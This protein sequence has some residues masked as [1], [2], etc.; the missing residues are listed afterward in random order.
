MAAVALVAICMG[1]FVMDAAVL[2]CALIAM[3]EFF[4]AF[5]QKGN[6]PVF[7]AGIVFWLMLAV[8]P[9]ASERGPGLIRFSKLGSINLFGVFLLASLIWIFAA[10][11]FRF[12]K[13]SAVD[14]A[15]T[16]FG[17]FYTV[18]LFSYFTLL[19]ELDGG[20][21]MFILAILGCVAADSAAY[22]IGT[23]FGKRKLA[24]RVSPNKTVEGSIA[25]FAGSTVF[26]GLYGVI[27]KL[28]HLFPS[29]PV[30]H[31]F[32]IGVLL[33]AVAQIGDLG[34]SAVKRYTGVKDFG[35]LIPGHG[36]I[37]DRF[38][39]YLIAVPIIFYYYTVF[40]ALCA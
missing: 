37:L 2:F 26:C 25:A 27:L 16:L 31:Y 32:I 33:G 5:K 7:G 24:P 21:Y 30:Y 40:L 19:R 13:Y 18:Y 14:G 35:K 39:A 8:M 17:S 34:A 3:H 9:F 11:I 28:F 38:D 4:S 15:I 1:G 23:K 36:G 10:M 6:H 29:F 22:M 12:E 20:F